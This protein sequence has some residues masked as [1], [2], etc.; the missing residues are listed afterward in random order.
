MSEP[1]TKI[2]VANV[3][4]ILGTVAI[5]A[6]IALPTGRVGRGTSPQNVC[7]NNLRQID[8]GKQQWALEY[9]KGSNDIPTRAE[10]ALYIKNNTFPVCPKGGTYIIGRVGADP[11]CSIPGHVL[12]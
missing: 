8:G 5:L 12:P 3:V 4:I 2:S 10:V 6:A 1:K 7:I 9:H 11:T